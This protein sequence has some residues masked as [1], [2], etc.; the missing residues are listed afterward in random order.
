MDTDFSV[1]N[2]ISLKVN[3]YAANATKSSEG[4]V[5]RV[6]ALPGGGFIE[7]T[8]SDFPFG[9]EAVTKGAV[10]TTSSYNAINTEGRSFNFEGWLGSDI[11]S[12]DAASDEDKANR[13]FLSTEPQYTGGKW[14]MP[15]EYWRNGIQTTFWSYY[16]PESSTSSISFTLPSADASDEQLK[17]LN[18]TCTLPAPGTEDNDALNLKDFVVA[19][20]HDVR[21]SSHA[22]GPIGIEF[23]HPLSAVR[24]AVNDGGIS[25]SATSGDNDYVEISKV[26]LVDVKTQ[27]SFTASGSDTN[28]CSISC[29]STSGSATYS[30][31]ST[32]ADIND[33]MFTGS[34][35]EYVFFMLPQDLTAV[36]AR[37]TLQK[38][39]K[40][41]VYSS[42]GYDV[43]HFEW[44][45]EAITETRVVT[46]GGSWE[47]GKYY[48][49]R[50]NATVFFGG[51][52]MTLPDDFEYSG[53]NVTGDGF[54]VTGRDGLNAWIAPLPCSDIKIIRV[55]L[56][57]SYDNP[58]GKSHRSIWLE[59]YA[60][61]KTTKDAELVAAANALPKASVFWPGGYDGTIR[62]DKTGR[63][64]DEH[65]TFFFY[66]GGEFEKIVIHFDY[67]GA[68]GGGSAAWHVKFP[69][70][71][72]TEVI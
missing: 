28:T 13:H 61:H 3:E 15:V 23:H 42:T 72:C 49:Y 33:G 66:L 25:G 44:S 70:F 29:N 34:S 6:I 50:I 20:N 38:R 45:D 21:T 65:E 57:H 9:D 2:V 46:L 19:Y 68:S 71:S 10:I 54:D 43:D 36:K 69:N 40:I 22:G 37:I 18:F 63:F 16:I 31:V 8:V 47:S 7:E 62:L 14:V 53:I 51:E 67:T 27:A 24:F 32:R 12:A 11:L 56:I 30:Q 1:D 59:D 5:S 64:V 35:S 4:D 39:R 60:T 48:T 55:D 17:S 58:N 26:E 41:T 52:S